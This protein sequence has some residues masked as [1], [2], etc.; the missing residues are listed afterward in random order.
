MSQKT[1]CPSTHWMGCPYSLWQ[2]F[3]RAVA[4]LATLSTLSCI[5]PSSIV[6]A[7]PIAP[8]QSTAVDVVAENPSTPIALAPPTPS[9]L[10]QLMGNMGN[11]FGIRYRFGGQT[12]AGFDCSGF[13]RYMFEKVYNIK[14]PHSS[15]EMSSLG[16]RISRE[17]LKPGDLVFF[18]SGKNRINH[19]G[20][21]IGNDAFIHSSLSKGITEDKLQHRYY[22]KRYAGA[23][24]ILPDITLPFSTPRQ[25][26]AQLEIIKPS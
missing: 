22:D 16:D 13:V 17:E 19:V 15:R 8:P 24:R 14:L 21:Y 7:N 2:R 4:A 23:V 9:K 1:I 5:A 26:D 10:E 25:E 18:H 3:S 11:Y 20:I 6:L 12:P